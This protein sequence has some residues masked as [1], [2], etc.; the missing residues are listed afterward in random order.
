MRYLN[1]FFEQ[2]FE[3][4]N[5]PEAHPANT[6]PAAD[7]AATPARA[8]TSGVFQFT[9]AVRPSEGVKIQQLE[10]FRHD[11]YV[12]DSS[13]ARVPVI[14][15]AV[16]RQRLFGTFMNLVQR[17]GPVVDVVLESSHQQAKGDPAGHVDYYREHIDSAVLTSVLWEYED[18]LM[19][20]GCTGIAVLNPSI[21]Q[22]VQFEEHKLL[23][24]YGSPLEP[25]EFALDSANIRE[26]EDLH[27][28]TEVEHVH[29]SS[30]HY[31]RQFEELRVDLGLDGSASDARD[32]Q[33]D[34]RDDYGDYGEAENSGGLM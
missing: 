13:G 7:P 26:T 15:A 5:P 3:P 19:N 25:Y 27:F 8:D 17:L 16:S 11:T 22:E 10:G 32:Q 29:A 14:M 2:T 28:I 9:D 34:D 4:V 31:A 30:G 21:P 24:C 23:I 1:R 18:L 12:D 33:H 6:P 20:D